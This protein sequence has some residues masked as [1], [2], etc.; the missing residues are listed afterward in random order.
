[1]VSLGF[2]ERDVA[3]LSCVFC[4]GDIPLFSRVQGRPEKLRRVENS[5]GT[6]APCA[7]GKVVDLS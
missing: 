4:K 1:M 7:V 5:A 2:A 6:R 3:V